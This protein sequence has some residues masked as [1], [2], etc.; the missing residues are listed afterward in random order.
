MRCDNSAHLHDIIVQRGPASLGTVRVR[1]VYGLLQ[2]AYP[3]I[4]MLSGTRVSGA[5]WHSPKHLKFSLRR[6]AGMP[7][8]VSETA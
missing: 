4:E 3:N 7:V 8:A 6:L 2:Q 1:S 5:R